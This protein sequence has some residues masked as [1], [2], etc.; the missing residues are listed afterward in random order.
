[1]IHVDNKAT[2]ISAWNGKGDFKRS[3]SIDMK[4]YAI[5]ELIDNG[6]VTPEWKPTDENVADLFTKPLFG[7]KFRKF[8]K[9]FMGF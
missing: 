1:M 7:P 5:K 6:I 4:Y 9:Y 3:K 2:I 8:R